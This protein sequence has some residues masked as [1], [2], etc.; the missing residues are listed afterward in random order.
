MMDHVAIMD[1]FKMQIPTLLAIPAVD[2]AI[3][4]LDS[5]PFST[6]VQYSVVTMFLAST[7]QEVLLTMSVASDNFTSSFIGGMKLM[8]L[9]CVGSWQIKAKDLRQCNVILFT[10]FLASAEKQKKS[11]HHQ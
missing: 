10:L 1:C 4:V 9:F 6:V 8:V 3:P 11:H 5:R 7:V 2:Q